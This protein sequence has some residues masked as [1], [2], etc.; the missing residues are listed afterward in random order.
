MFTTVTV[1]PFLFKVTVSS[2]IAKV[3]T[4]LKLPTA[5]AT[6]GGLKSLAVCTHWILF[7]TT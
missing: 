6:V 3:N 1:K 7:E 2:E 4:K 5:L